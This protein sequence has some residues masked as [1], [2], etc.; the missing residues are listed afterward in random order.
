VALILASASPRRAALL[1]HAGY[2]FVVEPAHFDEDEYL[3]Q[4]LPKK[5]AIFLADA[6]AREIARRFPDDVVLAAD[7]FVAFGDTPLGKPSS[8]AEARE[9]IQLLGGA[10]HLVITAV[11][12]H[13]A[14]RELELEEA[15]MSA[16]RMRSLTAGELADYLASERWR[17]K[18]GGYGIQDPD[19]IV[20]CVAGSPTNVVGLP[21][22]TTRSLLARAGIVP[23]ASD[24]AP[25]GQGGVRSV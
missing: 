24:N 1:S 5:L 11:A 20:T 6:K 13:C 8:T 15:V 4:F 16:V 22:G 23:R 17:T 3:E 14:S 9:M 18:A 19:P 21:M 12:V 2:E 25:G 7:S 10:T